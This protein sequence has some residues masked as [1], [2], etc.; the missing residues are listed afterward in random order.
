MLSPKFAF[1][2]SSEGRTLSRENLRHDKSR[3][4]VIECALQG[5]RGIKMMHFGGKSINE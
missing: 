4:R 1:E 2:L 3:Q 5:E